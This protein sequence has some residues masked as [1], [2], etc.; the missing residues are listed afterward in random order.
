MEQHETGQTS[1]EKIM[2]QL[3]LT[4]AS[5]RQAK[6]LGSDIPL[7][8]LGPITDKLDGIY[9]LISE[10][11]EFNLRHRQMYN[12]VADELGPSNPHQ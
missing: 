12:T 8:E 10:S 11:Q 9:Q 6:G 1:G 3:K 4:L 7:G 5:I 2:T